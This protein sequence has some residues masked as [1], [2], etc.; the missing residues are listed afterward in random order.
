MRGPCVPYVLAALRTAADVERKV[1]T[2]LADFVF[3]E[4]LT[5]ISG[6]AVVAG[7]VDF[8]KRLD[9]LGRRLEQK[10]HVASLGARRIACR[11]MR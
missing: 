6:E 4:T 7:R 11:L 5:R 10:L 9:G 3:Q 2:D 8:P 1:S